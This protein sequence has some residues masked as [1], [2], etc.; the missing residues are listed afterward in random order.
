MEKTVAERRFLRRP[1]WWIGVVIASVVASVV[2]LW[3]ADRGIPVSQVAET[4]RGP[5]LQTLGLVV[6]GPPSGPD[7]G[8]AQICV[9]NAWLRANV[10][11]SPYLPENGWND[12][13]GY[14]CPDEPDGS[15]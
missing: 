2:S 7:K 12:E 5:R 14:R 6:T 10:P 1:S 8:D 3:I 13:R 4:V 11:H 15:L 9:I